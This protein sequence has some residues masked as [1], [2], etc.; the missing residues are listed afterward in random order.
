[1]QAVLMLTE[2]VLLP[3]FLRSRDEN[4]RRLYEAELE[5]WDP[6]VRASLVLLPAKLV[7]T[8]NS[9]A[10]HFAGQHGVIRAKYVDDGF[11]AKL[12]CA[13]GRGS[14]GEKLFRCGRCSKAYYCGRD[15]QM[16]DRVRHKEG[17]CV[18]KN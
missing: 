1:M 2:M 12:C 16:G 5:I 3:F 17:G 15:C 4:V 13:C 6:C 10:E 11:V 14:Q 8:S 7:T 18:V 9:M